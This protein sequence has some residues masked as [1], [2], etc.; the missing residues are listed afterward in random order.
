[1]RRRALTDDAG[2]TLVELLVYSVLLTIVL[3]VA[4]GLLISTLHSQRTVREQTEASTTGQVALRLIE[5]SVRNAAKYNMPS[6]FGNNLLI[7][8]T[9]VGEDP[10]LASSWECR[11]WF[12]DVTTGDLRHTSSPATG[13]PVTAGL[14]MPIDTSTWDLVFEDVVKVPGEDIFQYEELGGVEVTF[15]VRAGDSMVSFRSTVIARNQ[16]E[17]IGGADCA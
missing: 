7:T 6:G 15:D 16:G 12:F 10:S 8:K 1:M 17:T 11:A 14:T 5:R 13:T 3:T 9:R 4:G 2:I